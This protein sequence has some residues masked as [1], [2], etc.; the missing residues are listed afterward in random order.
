MV[1]T[2]HQLNYCM[3]VTDTSHSL[4]HYEV[5]TVNFYLRELFGT[6]FTDLFFLAQNLTVSRVTQ[7]PLTS[8]SSA[9]SMPMAMI[10]PTGNGWEVAGN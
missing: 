7:A 2:L 1:I 10:T 5:H 9:A 3:S 4:Q 8:S 6:H